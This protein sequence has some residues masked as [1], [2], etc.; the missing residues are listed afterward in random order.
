MCLVLP[1]KQ[2]RRPLR[3]FMNELETERKADYAISERASGS[4][5]KPVH[6]QHG[7]GGA[8]VAYMETP[9]WARAGTSQVED[10]SRWFK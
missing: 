8:A 1:L 10:P 2:A 4:T 7:R 6:G 5:R 9:G 3:S